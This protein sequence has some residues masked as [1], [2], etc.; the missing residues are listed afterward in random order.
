GRNG[1]H[2]SPMAIGLLPKYVLVRA[3]LPQHFREYLASFDEWFGY[4][5]NY[6]HALAHRVP[7]YIPPRSLNPTAQANFAQ[8]ENEMVHAMVE[9]RHDRYFELR[10]AQ[11]RAGV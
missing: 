5:E 6:R 11:V 2:L 8:L 3:S 7:L 10:N 4:L 9:G 1:K